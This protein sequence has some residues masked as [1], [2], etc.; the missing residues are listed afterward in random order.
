M[1]LTQRQKRGVIEG[2]NSCIDNEFQRDKTAHAILT[3]KDG[4]TATI[5]TSHVHNKFSQL[6]IFGKNHGVINV[7]TN[8]WLPGD[9]N[10]VMLSLPGEKD[11]VIKFT[12]DKPLFSYEIDYVSQLIQSGGLSPERPG[13]TWEHSL[14]NAAWIE[15]WL[16]QVMKIE[17]VEH[18]SETLL[19]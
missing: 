14:G 6:T 3:F 2:T 8:P 12:V 11:D 5:T 10:E 19:H 16:A 18:E 13:V 7:M 15:E 1:D 9:V 17:V 4:L